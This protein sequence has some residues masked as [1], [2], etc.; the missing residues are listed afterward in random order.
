MQKT[1]RKDAG[2]ILYWGDRIDPVSSLLITF[3]VLIPIMVPIGILLHLSSTPIHDIY[4]H[5]SSL[6]E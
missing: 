4:L 1:N 5:Y 2:V 6:L 3:L